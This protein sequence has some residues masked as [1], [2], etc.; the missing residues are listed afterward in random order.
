MTHGN[1]ETST[2]FLP[3]LQLTHSLAAIALICEIVTALTFHQKALI[4]V[5]AGANSNEILS[6]G[7]TVVTVT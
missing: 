1:A 7:R 3:P 5:T 4:Q 6:T 2:I